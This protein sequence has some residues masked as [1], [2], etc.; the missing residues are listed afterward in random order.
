MSR[1]AQGECGWDHPYFP[2]YAGA[3][4]CGGPYCSQYTH[5]S[6]VGR[7]CVANTLNGPWGEW[8]CRPRHRHPVR[9]KVHASHPHN[10]IPSTM[11][12]FIPRPRINL[13]PEGYHSV[14]TSLREAGCTI[15]PY[16]VSHFQG[17]VQL[18]MH[19]HSRHHHTPRRH[20]TP[21]HP[22]DVQH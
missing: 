2:H 8:Y 11:Q 17:T 22:P 9:R 6:C 5:Y 13:N 21:R 3:A 12:N 18:V 19:P 16:D 10:I 20:H 15:N 1:G 7:S 14:T 4:A